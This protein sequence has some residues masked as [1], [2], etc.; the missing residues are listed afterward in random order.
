MRNKH[1][2]IES[3]IIGILITFSCEK[4]AE[5]LPS[6]YPHIV[7]KEIKDINAE[8]ITATA[9]ISS[10]GRDSIIDFGFVWSTSD[11]PTI[12][13]FKFSFPHEPQIGLISATINNC[14]NN[15]I[16]Y[17]IRP[18]ILSKK[19]LVYGNILEFK[20]LGSLNHSLIDFTPREGKIGSHILITG[21]NFN[22]NPI[23]YFGDLKAKVIKA[24]VNKIVVD[25]P[26]LTNDTKISVQQ[27]ST[28]LEFNQQFNII[29]PWSIISLPKELSSILYPA[30]FAINGKGYIISGY[31]LKTKSFSR[32]VWEF[33]PLNNE[34]LK[35][36]EFPGE[37]RENAVS[38]VTNNK[39]YVCFGNKRSE[40]EIYTD[41]WEYDSAQIY[42]LEWRIFQNKI[43]AYQFVFQT[44]IKVM[45]VLDQNSIK[46]HLVY[47]L[48]NFGVLIQLQTSGNKYQI[49]L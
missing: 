22:S 23:V 1:I 39:A 30:G 25:V 5:V 9:I 41:L 32:E 7:L 36:S 29:F 27:N 48:Q 47:F 31:S 12:D 2:F 4:D 44:I 37:G 34:W 14:I 35:K 16:L 21:N 46:L 33:N 3:F 38:F 45:L 8:G 40:S 10:L 43:M 11:K 6:D 18:F 19:Y 15:N 49:I 17:H 26:Y 24:F 28:K 20:G 42:G 13:N